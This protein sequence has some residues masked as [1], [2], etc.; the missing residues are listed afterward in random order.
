MF[1]LFAIAQT[2]RVHSTKRQNPTMTAASLINGYAAPV[3]HSIS[4]NATAEPQ[5]FSHVSTMS[6]Y[7]CQMIR[8]KD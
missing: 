3:R 6:E 5:I 1:S 7:L 2:I 8:E 4:T